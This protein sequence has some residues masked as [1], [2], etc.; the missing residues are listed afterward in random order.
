M[1]NKENVEI[2]YKKLYIQALA[3][4]ANLK[5]RAESVNQEN[6][7]NV[8]NSIIIDF[9]PIYTNAKRGLQYNEKGCELIFN[10]ILEIFNSYGIKAIDLEYIKSSYDNMFSETYAEAIGIEPTASE[11]LDNQ[12]FSVIEEGFINL[13][14]NSIIIPAKVI[15][16]KYSN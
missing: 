8:F 14:E 2:D 11:E 10:K 6:I 4:Y 9:V 1:E 15:V 13:R 7:R 3:D 5:R 12:I 16:F